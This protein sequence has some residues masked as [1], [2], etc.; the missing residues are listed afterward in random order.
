VPRS[1]RVF[2][3]LAGLTLLVAA[4]ASTAGSQ[5]AA[6]TLNLTTALGLVSVL[7]PCPPGVSASTCAARTSTGLFPGLGQVTGTYT[8]LSDVGP[9]SCANGFGKARAYPARF[10][11]ASKGEIDFDLAAGV[12]CVNEET[13][14]AVRAQTQ[15]FTVTGGTRIYAGASGSGTVT[16]ALGSTDS[17]SAGR[18]TW[19]GTLTVPGYEFDVTRPTLTGAVSRTVRAAK[20]AKTARVV[21]RVTAQDDRDAALPATCAPRSGSRFT[22]GRTRVKCSVT[23]TSANTGSASFVVTVKRTL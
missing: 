5:A 3:A 15:T 13:D 17:G 8:F 7:G 20:G 11:V 22:I 1:F 9:P 19:T 2:A 23:D 4:T 18:E 14:F 6:G 10:A 16:R 21:F 12:E